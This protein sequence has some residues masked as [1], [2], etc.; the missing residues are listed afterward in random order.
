MLKK[1]LKIHM[2]ESLE[3]N[4]MMIPL[5]IKKIF[6]NILILILSCAIPEIL[7]YIKKTGSVK[8]E[9]IKKKIQDKYPDAYK[10]LGSNIWFQNIIKNI[11]F[12][13]DE[14][15][16]SYYI[17]TQ[18][19]YFNQTEIEQFDELLRK[20]LDEKEYENIKQKIYNK[21]NI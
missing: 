3:L 9:Y 19:G 18:D 11:F 12:K 6:I 13:Q 5:S 17:I 1:S 15:K 4:E 10:Y 8:I 2:Q 20:Y 7:N 14:V 21:C 16:N